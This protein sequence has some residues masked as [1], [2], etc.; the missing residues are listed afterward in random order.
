MLVYREGGFVVTK[1]ANVESRP[2]IRLPSETRTAGFPWYEQGS[3][4]LIADSAGLKV[5]HANARVRPRP[6]RL[7]PPTM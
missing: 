1:G 7:F 5:A 3:E 2:W 6:V 4:G